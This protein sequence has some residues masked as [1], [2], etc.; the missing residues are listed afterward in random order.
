MSNVSREYADELRFSIRVDG[1]VV[2]RVGCDASDLGVHSL[3]G[4]SLDVGQLRRPFY[5][6]CY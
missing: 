1:V 5:V 4:Q 3:D 6:L 2:M